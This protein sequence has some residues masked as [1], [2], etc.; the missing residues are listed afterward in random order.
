MKKLIGFLIVAGLVACNCIGQ[1]V[2]TQTI[3]ATST[4]QA[5]LPNYTTI[6]TVSDNCNIKSFTQTPVAGTMLNAANPAVTVT[7]RAED[8]GGNVRT[9]SFQVVLLDTIKPVLNFPAQML[10]YTQ[11]QFNYVYIDIVEPYIKEMILDWAFNFDWNANELI[12]PG[13]TIWYWNH[14]VTATKEEIQAYKNR[15]P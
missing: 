1:V 13:D 11:E 9:K 14:V 6:V 15:Q 4:C 2:K 3:Y 7:L 8:N 12:I 5:P 10:A